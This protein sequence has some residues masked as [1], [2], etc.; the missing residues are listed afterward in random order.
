MLVLTRKVGER[1]LIDLGDTVIAV[2]TIG[3]DRDK[4]RIGIEGPQTVR[5]WREEIA[6]EDVVKRWKAQTKRE[7]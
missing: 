5:V 7:G 3:A 6:P 4:L 1:V 2:L